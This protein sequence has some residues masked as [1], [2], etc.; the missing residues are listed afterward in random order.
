MSRLLTA[1]EEERN[2]VEHRLRL[3]MPKWVKLN[4]KWMMR[5][6][7][8]LMMILLFKRRNW[9]KNKRV[10]VVLDSRLLPNTFDDEGFTRLVGL[11]H[12]L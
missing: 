5:L 4:A 6:I 12:P 10:V 11:V 7:L 3:T 9:I 8:L 2:A 1:V